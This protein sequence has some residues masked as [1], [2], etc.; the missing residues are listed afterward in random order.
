MKFIS[1][2]EIALIFPLVFFIFLACSKDAPFPEEPAIVN[3][4]FAVSAS[5]GGSVNSPGDSFAQNTTLTLTATAADGYEFTSWSGDASGTDNPLTLSLTSNT[6]ITANFERI[7]Y[8]LTVN[9]VGQGQVNQVLGDNS[10]T[11][12]TVEYNQGDRVTLQTNPGDNWTFSRWQGDATGYEDNFEILVDESKTVT[13]T[14]DFEVI[15]DLI[16]AWDIA[17]DSSSDKKIVKAPNS[18][19]DVI[20]GFYGL[21]FNPDYSFTLYYSLGT[22]SGEFYIQDPTSI[23]LKN[24]GSITNISFAANGISFNL[25]LD[26]GCSSDISGDK[27][28]D[29]DPENPP[30]SFLEKLDGKYFRGTWEEYERT[31]TDLISFKDNLPDDFLDLYWIDEGYECM[32]GTWN[33]SHIAEVIEN[34]DDQLTFRYTSGLNF[35]VLGD[36]SA[37]PMEGTMSLRSDGTIQ[38]AE[39]FQDDDL[40]RI[41]ILSEVTQEEFNQI[42]DSGYCY[43]ID[44]TPPIITLN[45]SSTI[46]LNI[47]ENWTDP[48]ATATDDLDGDLTSSISVTGSVDASSVG[49]YTLTYSVSDSAS[50][51]VSTTRTVIVNPSLDTTPPVI[52]LTGSSTINLTL[53][54]TFTDPG[55]AATDDVDGDLTSLISITGSV[56]TSSVGTYTLTYS[57]E[58]A[59]GN[60]SSI[61]RTVVVKTPNLPSISLSQLEG[62]WNIK[63]L[64]YL[65]DENGITQTFEIPNCA[66]QFMYHTITSSGTISNQGIGIN[67]PLNQCTSNPFDVIINQLTL[68]PNGNI[69]IHYTG[70]IKRTWIILDRPDENTLIFES[71]RNDVSDNYN[72]NDVGIKI[73]KEDRYGILPPTITL[74]GSSTINLIL[75]S[76]YS[77][78][79]A[80]ATDDVDGNLT[81]LISITGSVDT[82]SVGTYTLTYSVED[83]AG[84]SS[85]I[86]RTVVVKT[87]EL[88]IADYRFEGDA[89]DSSGNSNHGTNNGGVFT[90]DRF[91]NQ[92]GAIYFSGASCGTRMDSDIDMSTVINE[93]SISFWINR[94]ANGCQLPRIFDFYDGGNNSNDWGTAWQNGN[95]KY[96]G[97]DEVSNNNN[98]YHIVHN[99]NSNGTLTSFVDGVEVDSRNSGK[100]LPLSGDFALGRMNHPAYDA[101]NGKLDDVKMYNYALSQSEINVLFGNYANDTTAPIISLTGSSTINLTVGDTF[102]DPGATATDNVDGDI[103]S[104][105]TTSGSVNTSTAGTY[106]I[107]YSVSD[108][109]GNTA[110]VVQRT[111]TVNAAAVAC[112]PQTILSADRPTNVYKRIDGTYLLR[113]TT[114]V[115]SSTS[116]SGPYNSLGF[117]QTAPNAAANLLGETQNGDILVASE[118]NGLYRYSN[119]VWTAT[120]LSGGGTGGNNF[121]R[122]TSGRI[123]VGKKGGSRKMYYSDDDGFNWSAASGDIAEDWYNIIQTNNKLFVSSAGDKNKGGIITSLDDGSSWTNLRDQKT[124]SME[125]YNSDIYIVSEEG[126]RG[127]GVYKIFKSSDD[128][129]SWTFISDGPISGGIGVLIIHD[130]TIIFKSNSG[131]DY[132]CKSLND[133]T[134]DWNLFGTNEDLGTHLIENKI[135]DDTPLIFT[136]T[137][138]MSF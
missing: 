106:T 13:A 46:Q 120:G 19:K 53:G 48:G 39:N 7:Q 77:E 112:S 49:T 123:V 18:G 95:N 101:F 41:Y 107:S 111:I 42:I 78:L 134:S 137:Q 94:T 64:Y 45:S 16:G 40:D 67:W 98:W 52:N 25:E 21:I 35:K 104:S 8:T 44:T 87:P 80:T 117:T 57:V 79:G 109:A 9:I 34:Y 89:Q 108:A 83:A 65:N 20:C 43:D 1:K 66:K 105:I 116:L 125:M 81:S 135:I 23:S 128:G 36:A 110:T 3:Y 27:D 114:D 37:G 32:L 74:N 119:G 71:F 100:T 38:I 62:N 61:T 113:T 54:D 22:I 29:Y 121:L 88:I 72:G 136:T 122:L 60:S 31:F 103:T 76:N 63:E 73:V 132:Y 59:A 99:F 126:A 50:N 28:D 58:D 102:T 84:N 86:T 75:N 12:T 69:L 26:T 70:G 138:I 115:Y 5:E 93:F 33:S 4:N 90:T 118:S 56:D 85:S 51:I 47:G 131:G 17:S 129:Q 2:P 55:A 127:S 130:D 92:N 6:N 82:S 68:S 91:G 15:D 30:K 11:S 10:I 124:Y 96:Q 133:L 24:Y 97:Y 14:F